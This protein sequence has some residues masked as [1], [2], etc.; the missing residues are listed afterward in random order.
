MKKRY[1]ALVGLTVFGLSSCTIQGFVMVEPTIS[2]TTSDSADF[3]TTSL[4][5]ESITPDQE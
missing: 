5:Q 1:I 4:Y 3:V 2:S